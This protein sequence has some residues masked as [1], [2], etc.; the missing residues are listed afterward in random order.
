MA[1]QSARVV[2]SRI[3]RDTAAFLVL[4]VIAPVMYLA[5]MEVSIL[6]I[7]LLGQALL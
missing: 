1:G 2:A 7:M 3:L 5:G 4:G 6:L